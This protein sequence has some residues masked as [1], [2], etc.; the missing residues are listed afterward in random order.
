MPSP[1]FRYSGDNETI[2]APL[3][4]CIHHSD[5]TGA[6]SPVFVSTA[7]A[8]PVFIQK[9]TRVT[10]M[11]LTTLKRAKHREYHR[12]K[13]DAEQVGREHLTKVLKLSQSEPYRTVPFRSLP[14][15]IS[16]VPAKSKMRVE[17]RISP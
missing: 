17:H 15:A 10:M 11:S 5:V 16:V 13:D 12:H 2:V 6:G 7:S 8:A 1:S 14:T 9:P 3:A 4:Y